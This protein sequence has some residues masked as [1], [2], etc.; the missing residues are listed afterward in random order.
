M[1]TSYN[2]KIVTDGLVF[3]SDPANP[4]SYP[5]T[6]LTGTDLTKNKSTVSYSS[7]V[8]FNASNGGTM[9]LNGSAGSYGSGTNFLT[10]GPTSSFT[11]CSWVKYNSTVTS[12]PA[13]CSAIA[14]AA[15]TNDFEAVLGFPY[16][17]SSSKLGLEVGKAGVASQIAYSLNSN[18]TGV[19]YHLAGVFMNGSGNFYINGIYQSTVTYSA[20]VN[21][22]NTNSN[23]WIIGTETF[24]GSASGPFVN[25]NIGPTCVYNRILSANEI[26]Q[27]YNATKGRFG[28]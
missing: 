21:G 8:T 13:R 17:Y 16:T 14:K 4:K 3:Y 27:N 20:T 5:A 23:A 26:L 25:G 19:W 7:G 6:G 18:P 22:A 10:I 12:G 15:N 28:L 9:A 24:N 1:G 11:A 2:P